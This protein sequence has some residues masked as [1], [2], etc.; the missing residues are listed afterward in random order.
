MVE[1]GD[2]VQQDPEDGG[3]TDEA[4][5]KLDSLEFR[6]PRGSWRNGAYHLATTIATPAAFAPLPFAVAALGWSGLSSL[7]S[8]SAMTCMEPMGMPFFV[9][10][11]PRLCMK[12]GL[13]C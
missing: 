9:L 2:R 6:S 5:N 3:R 4:G 12:G 8:F 1:R 7:L 11:R 10:W 13:V